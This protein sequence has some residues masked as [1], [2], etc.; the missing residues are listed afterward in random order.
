MYIVYVSGKKY[1]QKNRSA[2]LL[3]HF[4]YWCVLKIFA[5]G[6]IESDIKSKISEFFVVFIP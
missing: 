1:I 2:T 5:K 3:T 4:F 6:N